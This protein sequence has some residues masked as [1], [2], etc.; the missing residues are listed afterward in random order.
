MMLGGM[1]ELAISNKSTARQRGAISVAFSSDD[2]T[3]AAGDNNGNT[4]LWNVVTGKPMTNPRRACMTVPPAGRAPR[5]G[6]V[7]KPQAGLW[8]E[9]A[10]ALRG[11]VHSRFVSRQAS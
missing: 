5:T 10:H 7:G 6:R 11:R 2:T 8:S 4:Y 9:F 1:L 3:L